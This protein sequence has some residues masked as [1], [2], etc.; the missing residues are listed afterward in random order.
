MEIKLKSK[1]NILKN[2][3]TDN[4]RFLYRICVAYNA[5]MAE[6]QEKKKYKH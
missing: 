3:D 2:I 5:Y 4:S 6:M 1:M